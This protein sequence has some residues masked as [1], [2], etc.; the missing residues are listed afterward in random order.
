MLLN[1]EK[2]GEQDNECSQE[3]LVSTHPVI[4]WERVDKKDLLDSGLITCM[5]NTNIIL[6]QFYPKMG[7]V[8]ARINLFI[9]L[10]VND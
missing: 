5:Y 4:V 6:N 8:G 10:Q 9:G 7:H 3:Y 1:T 2:S